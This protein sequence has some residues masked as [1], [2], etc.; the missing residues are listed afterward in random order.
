METEVDEPWVQA[1]AFSPDGR[2][3]AAA[4]TTFSAKFD[5]WDTTT[6]KLKATLKG[7]YGSVD[8]VVFSPDGK[9][10][11]AA[12]RG[13]PITL[14]NAATFQQTGM[15]KGFSPIAFSPDGKT[16]AHGKLT[17]LSGVGDKKLDFINTIVIQKTP[18][19]NRR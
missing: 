11:A 4:A 19:A 9:M 10:L 1:V 14:W 8:Q 17:N 2:T 16:I 5:L 18:A 13:G 3:L 6:G 15:I 12:G 7:I